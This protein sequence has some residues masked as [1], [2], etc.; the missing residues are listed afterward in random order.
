MLMFLFSFKIFSN[1]SCEFLFTP[2]IVQYLWLFQRSVISFQSRYIMVWKHTLW[3]FNFFFICSGLWHGPEHR[4]CWRVSRVR[5]NGR[6]ALLWAR[7]SGWPPSWRAGL[8]PPRDGQSS[9]SAGFCFLCVEVLWFCGYSSWTATPSF[10]A[11]RPPIAGDLH[12]E[13]PF[14]WCWRGHA[15]F[16]VTCVSKT[17]FPIFLLSTCL[18]VKVGFLEIA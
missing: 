8:S 2:L 13:I 3:D 1:F 18:Y 15:G 17:H 10:I 5:V 14:V 12:L 7:R 4:A 16:P 11:S 6:W 9:G